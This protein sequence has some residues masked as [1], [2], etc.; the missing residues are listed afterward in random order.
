MDKSVMEV[1]MVGGVAIS[2]LALGFAW[3]HKLKLS[4][5]AWPVF[6]VAGA[7]TGILLQRPEVMQW[8]FG[9][10]AF[11]MAAQIVYAGWKLVQGL[12]ASATDK[13]DVVWLFDCAYT[14]WRRTGM[15]LRMS[16]SWAGTLKG[17]F[18]DRWT[19]RQAAEH[20]LCRW[21]D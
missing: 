3:L 17:Q 9:L 21:Q 14:L 1:F 4:F 8:S 2:V 6:G 18:G 15:S 13:R 12:R 10:A 20:Q 11:A 5:M 7:V 16:L 19:G